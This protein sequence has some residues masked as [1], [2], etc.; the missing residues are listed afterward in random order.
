MSEL[1]AL[2]VDDEVDM[3][4][5]LERIL[6]GVG[7]KT[8]SAYTGEGALNVLKR[9]SIKLAFVDIKL[10]DMDGIELTRMIKASNPSLPVILISGYYYRDDPIVQEGLREGLY[11]G[12][13]GKPFDIIEIR[14]HIY[15]LFPQDITL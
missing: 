8:H 14:N 3:C 13:V 12:F 7:F 6:Q 2:V 9:D 5:V 1:K 4:W 10:P 15:R 11:T